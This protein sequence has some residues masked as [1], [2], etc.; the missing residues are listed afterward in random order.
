MSNGGG[1][2]RPGRGSG[3]GRGR[4]DRGDR[5][6]HGGSGHGAGFTKNGNGFGGS[7]G[8]SN[9][10]N[11]RGAFSGRPG[12]FVAGESSG[13][14]GDDHA[15]GQRFNGEFAAEVGQF[16]RGSN[17][18]NYNRSGG[19]QQYRPRS[20]GNN[21]YYANNRYGYNG[22]R[23]NFNQN[24]SYGGGSSDTGNQN[25]VS[26]AG[27]NPDMIKEAVQGVVAALAAAAQRGGTETPTSVLGDVVPAATQA[28]VP[29]MQ[30]PQPL[31]TSSHQAQPMQVETET[32]PRQE[33]TNP[34]KKAKKTDKNPCFRCKQ[35]GHQIDTCTAPVCDICE[36]TNHI[37]SACPLLNAP[38]PSVTMYG[39][40]IEQLMFFEVPTW[41]SYKPKVDNLKLV[42]VTIEGDPMV[43]FPNKSE[44]Q[45]MKT[46]RTY[47]VP[48]RASDLVFEDCFEVE[49][50][51]VTQ[52][53]TGDLGN[54]GD[55]NGG[56][57]NNGSSGDKTDDATDMDFEKT[58]SNEQQRNT[59]GQQGTMKKVNNAKSVSGHQ[60]QHQ[61]ED[62]ILF[63]S[64]KK[65][66]LSNASKDTDI[67]SFKVVSASG[68]S[69]CQPAVASGSVLPG[70]D[71]AF[72][73]LDREA[74]LG[75]Q[76]VG[77]GEQ[78]VGAGGQPVGAC[79]AVVS[80][81]AGTPLPPLSPGRLPLL[82][83]GMSTVAAG[84]GGSAPSGDRALV[85]DSQGANPDALPTAVLS[86]ETLPTQT[87]PPPAGCMAP[88]GAA[89]LAAVDVG[90]NPE[91]HV[92]PVQQPIMATEPGLQHGSQANIGLSVASPTVPNLLL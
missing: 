51:T 41:G 15:H 10:S 67:A 89:W 6:G 66:L 65:D 37:S 1:G 69:H 83:P 21:N 38:K 17:F 18:N 39:Y 26:L 12:N 86:T 54:D 28:A 42:K 2:F 64:L 27:I 53:G 22:G 72:L 19:N 80:P 76:S 87:A 3:P 73:P 16:N 36:S 82:S 92:S 23:S 74:T 29:V 50:V 7:S 48:D 35:P 57:D 33:V 5:G 59:N 81:R 30:Q 68:S 91:N 45:R 84:Q 11:G 79:A 31:V 43:K 62:P 88:N 78:P 40:A 61:I 14:A 13:T 34:A 8:F 60:A 55:N 20:Y 46:F 58:L 4:G 90:A 47:P 71:A 70:L 24:R 63:G 75:K 25:N 32:V 44:A 77:A 56:G 52:L 49:Q 9:H 85:A